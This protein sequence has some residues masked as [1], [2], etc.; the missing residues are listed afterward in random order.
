[1]AKYIAN[2]ALTGAD[3]KIYQQGDPIEVSEADAK[4]LLKKGLIT[5]IKTEKPKQEK[6]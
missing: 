2:V 5:E 6:K 1:M 4:V 3:K